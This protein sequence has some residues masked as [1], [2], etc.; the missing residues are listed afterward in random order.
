MK[1]MERNKSSFYYC[2]YQ[3]EERATDTEGNE[4]GEKQ[5]LYS[6]PVLL[7]ANISPATGHASVEQFGNDLQY[8]KVIVLDD[9]TCPIDEHSVLFI[10]KTPAFDVDGTPLFD[11]LV[12]KV[13][14]SLSSISIAVGKVEVS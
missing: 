11:Y 14:R 6:P 5:V 13:A 12:K 9:V 4:T 10:D 7:R 8:D 2:L 3:G 1:C